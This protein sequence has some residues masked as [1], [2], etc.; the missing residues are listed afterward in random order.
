MDIIKE[1]FDNLPIAVCFFDSRGIVRLVNRRMLH[2]G[3]MLLG[4]GFQTLSE[5]TVALENPPEN[6]VR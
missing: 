2:V 4:G 6:V 5:I 3:D 1:S